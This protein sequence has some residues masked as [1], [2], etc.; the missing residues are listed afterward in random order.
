LTEYAALPSLRCYVLLEQT[1]AA[2]TLYQREFGGAWTASAHTAGALNIAG[3]DVVLPLAEIYR[4]LT[5]PA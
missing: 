1:T 4:G 5:F 3:L 2:A